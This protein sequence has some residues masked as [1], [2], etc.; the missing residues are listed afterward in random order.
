KPGLSPAKI[1]VL[2]SLAFQI[3]DSLTLHRLQ[4]N[5][6]SGFQGNER[7]RLLESVVVHAKDAIL[8]TEAEP[9][10]LPGPRI[11]YC[12][13][14]FTEATGYSAEEVIGQ[15]WR[16]EARSPAGPC[17]RNGFCLSSRHPTREHLTS[18]GNLI[19]LDRTHGLARER[20]ARMS[21]KGGGLNR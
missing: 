12:N 14:A 2:L 10:D 17:R 18:G 11:V 16:P 4:A 3:A 15:P 5:E 13:A 9:L 21:P 8:I 7:L 20:T 6:E 1:Y 19:S